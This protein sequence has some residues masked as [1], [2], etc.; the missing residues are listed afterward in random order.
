MFI[1]FRKRIVAVLLACVMAVVGIAFLNKIKPSQSFVLGKTVVIDAGHGGVDGGV[2]GANTGVKESD[3]NLAVSKCLKEFL[4]E[5]GY[6]VVMTRTSEDSLKKGK[7]KDMEARK[8]II[9]DAS[10][11]LVVSIHQN[12]YPRSYVKGA[13]VFFAPAGENKDI[14][15]T[16]QSVLN[17]RLGCA[18]NA[19]KG[20]YYILQCSSVPSLLV[21][22]G[23]LSNPE[24]EALLVTPDYQQKVAYAIFCGINHIMDIDKIVSEEVFGRLE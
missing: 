1:V 12:R 4:T 13:Q 21:E 16:M 19:A 2:V 14:A 9:L 7:L 8:D 5:A 10:A 17:D 11:H 20:D 3:I 6:R 23:F 24:E 18:R 22:C 15:D